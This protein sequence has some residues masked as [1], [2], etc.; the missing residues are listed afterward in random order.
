L[1]LDGVDAAVI[2]TVAVAFVDDH[3]RVTLR[4]TVMIEAL[5]DKVTVGSEGVVTATVTEFEAAP[6][7]PVQENV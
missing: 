5:L 4:P 6:P 3:I 7:A 1:G 2:V